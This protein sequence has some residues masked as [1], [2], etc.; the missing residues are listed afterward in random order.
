ML[1]K[2]R[3]RFYLVRAAAIVTVQ[4]GFV[5]AKLTGLLTWSWVWVFMPVLITGVILA[6]A[7]CAAAFLIL[8]SGN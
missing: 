7:L 5:V 3:T 2:S 6:I 1:I 4:L 8:I